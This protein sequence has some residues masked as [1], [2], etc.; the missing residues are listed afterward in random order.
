MIAVLVLLLA[1][2]VALLYVK[3]KTPKTTP[4]KII[5]DHVDIQVKDIVYTDVGADGTKWEVRAD[6]GVYLR[7]ENRALFD[8]VRVTLALPDG[9]TFIMKGDSGI[10][11]TESKD[12]SL[13]G[14]VVLVSD[15]GDRITMED[16]RYTAKD[17][18]MRT[19]SLVVQENE[20][21][22]LQGRGMVLSLARREL[23]LLANVRALIK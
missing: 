1:G 18:S 21:M 20:R 11:G 19:D 9:R 23:T 10:L 12:M 13:A 3:G 17:R 2:V 6:T 22:R 14:N 5:P 16:L 7:K 8:N 15:R 4:L